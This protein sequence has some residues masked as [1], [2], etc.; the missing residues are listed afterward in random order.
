MW[1]FKPKS[2]KLS[3]EEKQ[4]LRSSMG[5]TAA[6][7]SDYY[8]EQYMIWTAMQCELTMLERNSL[9]TSEMV[10]EQK[11]KVDRIDEDIKTLIN[12][13]KLLGLNDDI[14]QPL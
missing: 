7:L 14:Q 12:Q 8:C 5:N 9:V 1:F 11:S 10:K 2:K 13:W 6:K 3:L 4:A